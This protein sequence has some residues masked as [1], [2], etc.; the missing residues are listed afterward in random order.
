MSKY[1]RTKE[2]IYEAYK[3]VEV[4]PLDNSTCCSCFPNESGYFAKT[5]NGYDVFISKKDV[6]RIKERFYEELCDCFVLKYVDNENKEHI[7]VFDTYEEKDNFIDNNKEQIY[8]FTTYGAI[9]ADTCIKYVIKIQKDFSTS[10]EIIKD[11]N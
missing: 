9:Y 5:R 2:D 1:I 7:K 4:E 10:Y 8:S 11:K 3:E 6:I